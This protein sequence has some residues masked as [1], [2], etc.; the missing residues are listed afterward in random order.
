M[1]NL[2]PDY[3]RANNRYALRNSHLLRYTA[4]SALTMVAI[5]LITGASILSMMHTQNSLQ[6]QVDSQNKSLAKYKPLEAQGQQLSSELTTINALLNR[7][8]NFSNLLPDLAKIMPPGAI[9]KQL[10]F[11][12]SDI[13]VSPKPANPTT[14]SSGPSSTP[15]PAKPFVILAAVSDR[16]T[17][18]IL[19][20]NIK[21]NSQ[22]FTD[23]DI[24][25]VSQ[26][27]VSTGPSSSLSTKYPYQV[28]INAYLK[29]I[30]PNAANKGTK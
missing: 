20:N 16:A 1:I 30:N 2:I 26:T 12:T 9:L 18:T 17:A 8:V 4:I 11:S 23:A 5:G 25:D 22:L 29:K 28:T 21:S 13:L 10:D 3:I 19:L 24:V 27:T 6:G 15:A 14:G 7:Q